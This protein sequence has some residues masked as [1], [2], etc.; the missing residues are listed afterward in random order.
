VN[1][2]LSGGVGGTSASIIPKDDS[3]STK[4]GGLKKEK[5]EKEGRDQLLQKQCQM[6]GST[7]ERKWTIGLTRR[8]GSM[9]GT[10]A[11]KENTSQY[12]RT[13]EQ[14]LAQETKRRLKLNHPCIGVYTGPHPPEGYQ[15]KRG[16]LAKKE[17]KKNIFQKWWIS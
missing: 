17:E 1:E 14:S 8:C 10:A 7:Q 12:P 15:G 2:T 4:K 3:G 11:H 9:T 6:E 16:E 13:S 5:G